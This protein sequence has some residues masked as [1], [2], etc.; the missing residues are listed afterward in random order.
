MKAQTKTMRV[1]V[2]RPFYLTR[3]TLAKPGQEVDLDT[4]LAGAMV[5]G[6][7]AVAVT[8]SHVPVEVPP[9]EPKT[10]RKPDAEVRAAAAPKGQSNA[11]QSSSK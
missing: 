11:R 8:A 1:R 7:K 2:L 5:S 4:Q 3:E 6:G 9:P 10:F